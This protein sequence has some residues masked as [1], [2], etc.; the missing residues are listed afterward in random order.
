[1]IG[2]WILGDFH[3]ITRS[4]F[5]NTVDSTKLG[6]LCVCWID[7]TC[8]WYIWTLANLGVGENFIAQILLKVPPEQFPSN[9][10]FISFLANAWNNFHIEIIVESL[11]SM[12]ISGRGC[13]WLLFVDLKER[14]QRKLFKKKKKQL[15]QIATPLKVAMLNCCH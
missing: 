4:D 2:R 10:G 7:V 6:N 15:L 1:M 8:F 14:S 9:S 13:I 12:R 3:Q 5:K 11:S